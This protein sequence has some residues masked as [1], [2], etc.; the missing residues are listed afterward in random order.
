MPDTLPAADPFALAQSDN[1]E[2]VRAFHAMQP[3]EIMAE[4]E[5]LANLLGPQARVSIGTTCDLSAPYCSGLTAQ[6][7]P[8]GRT[9]RGPMHVPS[10]DFASLIAEAERHIAQWHAHRQDRAREA[11]AKARA[12]AEAL[13]VAEVV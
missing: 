9:M 5:R 4:C 8:D 6:L 12:E 7:Y 3:R 11:L 13:G 2:R 1:P 10:T